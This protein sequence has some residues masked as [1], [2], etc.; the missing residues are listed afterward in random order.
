[1]TLRDVNCLFIFNPMLLVARLKI[2]DRSMSHA[3]WVLCNW[4]IKILTEF[5]SAEMFIWFIYYELYLKL[6]TC[7]LL[8]RVW[9]LFWPGFRPIVSLLLTWFHEKLNLN[10]QLNFLFEFY[11]SRHDDQSTDLNGYNRTHLYVMIIL[12][13]I[14]EL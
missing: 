2:C 6:N 7:V 13:V 14:S 11:W 3:A 12:R 1:M 4:K 5:A 9:I 8:V 10:V